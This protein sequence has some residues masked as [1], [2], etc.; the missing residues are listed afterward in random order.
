MARLQ[1]YGDSRV[2][3]FP[4]SHLAAA[5]NGSRRLA[6]AALDRAGRPATVTLLRSPESKRSMPIPGWA[7]DLFRR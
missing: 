5:A 1:D 6:P 7:P 4:A 2:I 3:A